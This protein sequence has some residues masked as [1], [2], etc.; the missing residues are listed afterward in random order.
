MFSLQ[1]AARESLGASGE[2]LGSLQSLVSRESV[3]RESLG[4]LP[5]AGESLG[6]L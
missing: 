5:G 2:S 3:S 1:E 4:S 6:S